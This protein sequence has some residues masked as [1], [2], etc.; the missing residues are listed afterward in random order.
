[1]LFFLH[2]LYVKVTIYCAINS[3]CTY[4]F[5]FGTHLIR[6]KNCVC[7]LQP[8]VWLYYLFIWCRRAMIGQR[9]REHSLKKRDFFGDFSRK[10]LTVG[11]GA[12]LSV[13]TLMWLRRV[14]IP[15]LHTTTPCKCNKTHSFYHNQFFQCLC[16]EYKTR[17]LAFQQQDCGMTQGEKISVDDRSQDLWM[18]DLRNA[19]RQQPR[20]HACDSQTV[21]T[22]THLAM[23]VSAAA[24]LCSH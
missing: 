10:V 14:K 12:G 20:L 16:Q 19:T 21:Q 15:T 3:V 5:F 1:M 18:T 4:M 9:R 11:A 8:F 23:Q 2:I 7:I 24:H 6:L 22:A 17:A 13:L